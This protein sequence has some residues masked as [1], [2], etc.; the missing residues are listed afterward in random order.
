MLELLRDDGGVDGGIKV[1]VVGTPEVQE[2]A[3][4]DVA[5]WEVG[6]SR[7][8]VVGFQGSEGRRLN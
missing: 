6:E 3:R 7:P 2:A 1:L 4:W 8:G 5:A